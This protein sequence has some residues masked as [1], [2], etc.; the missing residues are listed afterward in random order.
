MR[1]PTT[2]PID[3]AFFSATVPAGRGMAAKAGAMMEECS[4][5]VLVLGKPVPFS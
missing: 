1:S 2:R 4:A 3:A 5:E